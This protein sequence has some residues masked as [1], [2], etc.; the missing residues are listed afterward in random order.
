MPL[1]IIRHFA[2]VLPILAIFVSGYADVVRE[3]IQTGV[4]FDVGQIPQSSFLSDDEQGTWLQ[5]TGVSITQ[6]VDV[7]ERLRLIVGVGGLFFNSYPEKM[8]YERS[9]KF[10]PGVGQAQGIYKLGN[11]SDSWGA[12]R[13]GLIPYKYNP[14]AKNLG[15]YLLRSTAYP[16]VLV[17]GGFSIIN[18]ASYMM[19]G[20]DFELHTGPV[21]HNVFIH[22]ERGYE[23]TGDISPGYLISYS[24]H[25]SVELGAGA[26]YAHLIPARPSVTTPKASI[27]TATDA[28]GRYQGD[29]VVTDINDKGGSYYTFKAVKIVARASVNFQT[30]LKSD[31]FG[32]ED[33]K[34]YSEA[35][36]LGVK[37]YPFYYSDVWHRIPVMVGLNLPTFKFLDVLAVEGEYRKADFPNSV[38][39]SYVYRTLPIPTLNKGDNGVPLPDQ[40]PDGYD[41]NSLSKGPWYRNYGIKWSVYAKR[42]IV[43][44]LAAFVQVASDHNRPVSFTSDGALIPSYEPLTRKPSDWYYMVRL[45]LGI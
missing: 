25:P 21:K 17:T 41:K 26:E 20:I 36:V 3:P 43:Q 37:N 32:P 31:L 19:Q 34:L 2:F 7:G 16:N 12:L 39:Q 24:P 18:S 23:P 11:M 15:E 30:L 5:R 45:Q 4:S 13:F 33:L 29:T 42:E 40:S 9:L 22:S 38:Y 10:G 1:A 27:S 8:S 14:D 44:G 28:T 35:A 6:A